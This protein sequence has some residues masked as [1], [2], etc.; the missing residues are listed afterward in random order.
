MGPGGPVGPGGQKGRRTG[1]IAAI[2]GGI[3]LVVVVA[4][5]V[6]VVL[7][8]PGGGGK[9]VAASTSAPPPAP[10]LLQ[11]MPSTLL[12]T[13][14]QIQTD[15]LQTVKAVGDQI[16]TVIDDSVT[17][18]PQ[19]A[20]TDVPRSQSSWGTATAS[21]T[22]RYTDTGDANF[23]ALILAGA[24]VF[25]TVDAAN[26]SLTAVTNSVQNCRLYSETGSDNQ[27]YMWTVTGNTTPKPGVVVW[28]QTQSSPSINWK[29][30]AA[31][32]VADNVAVSV[33]Q[34]GYGATGTA[35]K[36]AD[37]MLAAA[38]K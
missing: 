17:S 9:P 31:Y 38:T 12:P 28:T 29:C 23:N 24:A 25:P 21:A 32:E 10:K 16:T 34:C 30:T 22:Q 4:V 19:C 14:D 36:V 11:V 1:L 6:V 13:V 5:V 33:T 26:A 27:I 18:D 20:L 7:A 2:A 8:K 37:T 15:T 3:V 35:Q